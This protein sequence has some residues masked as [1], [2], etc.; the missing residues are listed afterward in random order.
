MLNILFNVSKAKNMWPFPECQTVVQMVLSVITRMFF[1][2]FFFRYHAVRALLMYIVHCT[3]YCTKL[4][5]T[6]EAFG[7]ERVRNGSGFDPS[8]L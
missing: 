8:W 7:M 3:I 5:K 6:Q 1:F 4:R 2:V